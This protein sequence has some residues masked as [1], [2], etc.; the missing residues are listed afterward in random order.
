M[1]VRS[2]VGVCV[3]GGRETVMC[4]RLE[5]IYKGEVKIDGWMDRRRRRR[6]EEEEEK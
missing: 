6:G 4:E 5:Y 1:V 2:V 3:V